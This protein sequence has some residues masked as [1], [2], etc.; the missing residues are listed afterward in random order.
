MESGCKQL[1]SKFT[2]KMISLIPKNK[3]KIPDIDFTP[4]IIEIFE[5]IHFN[6]ISGVSLIL[7]GYNGQG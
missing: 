2:N 3:Y 6:L 7:D 5:I 1:E 4:S